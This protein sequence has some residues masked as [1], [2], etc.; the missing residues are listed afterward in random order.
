MGRGIFEG[1]ESLSNSISDFNFAYNVNMVGYPTLSLDYTEV[2]RNVHGAK[3]EGGL[4]W[5]Y[6]Y[7]F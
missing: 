3:H 7:K 2:R 6:F 4:K 5:A 1:V